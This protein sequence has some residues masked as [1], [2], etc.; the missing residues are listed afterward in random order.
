MSRITKNFFSSIS[1]GLI[2]SLACTAPG[3]LPTVLYYNAWLAF[4]SLKTAGKREQISRKTVSLKFFCYVPEL[5][6]LFGLQL[7]KAIHLFG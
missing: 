1:L 5:G 7:S 2:A 4:S 3:Y 6:C